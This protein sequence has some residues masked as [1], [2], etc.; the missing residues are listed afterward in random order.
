METVKVYSPVDDKN[1]KNNLND[2]PIWKQA[3]SEDDISKAKLKHSELYEYTVKFDG[4]KPVQVT[5][6]KKV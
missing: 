4:I 6:I 2:S 5:K 1:I 3:Y